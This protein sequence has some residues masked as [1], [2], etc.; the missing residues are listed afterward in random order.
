MR[1]ST[2]GDHDGPVSSEI[3][4][5]FEW[6]S[7][8][9]KFILAAAFAVTLPSLVSAGPI[10]R[11]VCAVKVVHERAVLRA[12]SAKVSIAT[13][14]TQRMTTTTTA[15]AVPYVPIK[16]M[17]PSTLL[18]TPKAVAPKSAYVVPTYRLV[19]PAVGGCAN[20]KCNK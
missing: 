8:L 1:K 6:S 13:T 15:P 5:Y 4:H 10:A 14:T 9:K 16:P 19:I 17:A 2:G 3:A 12:S 11:L 20:G 7:L 18:P